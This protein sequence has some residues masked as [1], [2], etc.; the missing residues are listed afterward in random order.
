MPV[1]LFI[2]ILRWLA[3]HLIVISLIGFVVAGFLVFGPSTAPV[4]ADKAPDVAATERPSAPVNT[5]PDGQTRSRPQPPA[6]AEPAETEDESVFRAADE[7]GEQV[8]DTPSKRP[9][10]IGGTLPVYD[11]RPES[12]GGVQESFDGFRPPK[13]A[14]Q[15]A[16]DRTTRESQ[17]QRARQAFWNGDFEAAETIYRQITTGYPDDAD[18][19][20][21]LGNL[22]QAM[23]RADAANDAYFEAGMQLK[24][25]GE[26]T[27]LRLVAEILAEK[28]DDRSQQLLNP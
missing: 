24:R 10:L 17:I 3:C 9:R 27:R 1:G 28:G 4:A 19:F 12:A 15:P 11:P 14:A 23:G 2:G 5:P 8:P 20:G 6:T 22:Y 18:A 13:A 26:T 7:G 16:P 25:Q 21:E